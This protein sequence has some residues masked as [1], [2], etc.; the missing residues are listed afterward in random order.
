MK[1]R[2][3]EAIQNA[4]RYQDMDARSDGDDDRP[5][6]QRAVADIGDDPVYEE[7]DKL[8]AAANAPTHPGLALPEPV[9]GALPVPVS[10]AR[11][12]SVYEAP[13]MPASTA[14]PSPALDLHRVDG[15]PLDFSSR[16]AKQEA[17]RQHALEQIYEAEQASWGL[18]TPKPAGTAATISAGAVSSLPLPP[19]GR[20]RQMVRPAWLVRQEREERGAP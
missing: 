6:R 14:A 5:V 20:G 11:P 12:P 8:T 10:V 18:P 3:T 17:L 15:T 2:E 9:S 7:Y 19:R 13:P 4:R 16:E 1:R